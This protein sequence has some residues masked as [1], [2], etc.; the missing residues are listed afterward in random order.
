MIKISHENLLGLKIRN[1][2][3]VKVI[4]E[5]QYARVYEAFNS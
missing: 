4:G 3:F 2:T 5:G 1:Y